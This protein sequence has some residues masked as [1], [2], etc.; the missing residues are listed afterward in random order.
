MTTWAT[1]TGPLPRAVS[2]T[3]MHG[4][5]TTGGTIQTGLA[6]NSL[7]VGGNVINLDGT[8]TL[9]V[10]IGVAGTLAAATSLEIPVA[11][12]GNFDLSIGECVYTGPISIDGTTGKA[13]LLVEAV[14]AT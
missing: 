5:V 11:A 13:Y 3:V 12:L 10:S 1:P 9:G 4:T 8:A 7:R 2:L 14:A 6:A